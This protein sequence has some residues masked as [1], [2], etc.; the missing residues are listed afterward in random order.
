M[1]NT[2]PVEV[3]TATLCTEVLLEGES[4]ALDVF[5]APDGLKHSVREAQD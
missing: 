4:D 3:A 2:S 1:I 5:A